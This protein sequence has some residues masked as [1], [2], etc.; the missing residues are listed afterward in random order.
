MTMRA[1][2]RE[3]SHSSSANTGHTTNRMPLGNRSAGRLLIGENESLSR[4]CIICPVRPLR[5]S[6]RRMLATRASFASGEHPPQRR[7]QPLEFDRLGVELVA[8][9]A[10]RLLALAGERVRGERNDRDAAGLWIV[11]QSS[12]RLPAVDYRHFEI[13]QDDVGALAQRHRAA[14]FAVRRRYNLELAQELEPHLEHVDVVLVVLDVEYFGH[15]AASIPLSRTLASPDCGLMSSLEPLA[16]APTRPGRRTV[17]TEPLPGSLATVTSPPIMRAS[18]RVMAKPSPVPPYCRAVEESAWVNSS[19]SLACCSGVIPMPVSATAISIQL[20]PSTTLLTRSL[21]SPCLVNLQALLNR[22]SRIC[23]S[24]MG[25]T[26]NC[27]RFSWASRTSRFLFCSASCRA[28][29]MTSSRSGAKFTVSG[30]SSSLPA[31]IL[32]RSSTW[33]MRP[34]RWVP[35]RWTRRSGS[36]AFSVPKRGA[37]LTIISVSPMMAL[38]GVR[39]SWL[40]LATNCDLCWLAIAS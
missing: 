21:T 36:S 24:R 29:P 20:R 37:L 38:S 19:N 22:L 12:R 28:V 10:K 23:R 33:L 17:K 31:S 6:L 11:L 4:G 16:G 35:A 1:I 15:D 26:V 2:G 14:L 30:L 9:G 3:M 39:S 32:E 40:M 13:H 7:D 25:S 8:S 5:R 34:S 18:L 27:P